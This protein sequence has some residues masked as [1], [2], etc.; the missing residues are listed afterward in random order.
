MRASG[1]N[2][3]D[4]PDIVGERLGT[5]TGGE[6]VQ[7]RT[8]L[9]TDHSWLNIPWTGDD[10]EAW[11]AGEYTD[12]SRSAAYNQVVD[13]WY[14]TDPVLHFRRALVR[15]LLRVRGAHASRLEQA[16]T[17]RG[18]A[19]RSMEDSLTGPSLPPAVTDFWE[20]QAR[21]GL[22]DPFDYLPVHTAPPIGID[23]LELQ[24][25]G[26]TA[27]ARDNWPLYYEATRGMHNGIDFQVPEGSPLIA[28]ADGQ[29]V[30]FRFLG[31]SGEQ[32]MALR[33]YLPDHFLSPD[34]SRVLSN[35]IVA[36]GHL[37]GDP[38]GRLVRPGD[39]VRAGQVIGTSG[40]P[41]YVRDD[42]SLGVQGNNAHLHIEVHLVTHG[43]AAL[44]SR[45][46]FNPLLFW[47]PRLVA[48][49]ARLARQSGRE[50]YPSSGQPWG[51][52]GLFTIGCFHYE[53]PTIVWDHSPSRDALWP[54]AV[55]S[56]DAMIDYLETFAPY[57]TDGSSVY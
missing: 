27:F 46:P 5:L 54:D 55:F 30:D 43:Q 45:Q 15:D 36:Y 29:I 6:R 4:E 14:E 2:V 17:L 18:D 38:T 49:Q 1:V 42:G 7:A 47:T 35:V 39:P 11:I 34:G 25:F 16:A 37:T 10:N 21:L 13:A 44:G 48:M 12:F 3:R 56:L 50:P 31:T 53:P 52:L 26:P 41:V 40:W 9:F 33:P 24:G 57:P 23:V 8:V 28:V 19:L 20:M 32:S 22:P 51:R